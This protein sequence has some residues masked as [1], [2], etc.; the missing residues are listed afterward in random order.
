MKY[1]MRGVANDTFLVIM[2]AIV[3]LFVI[4]MESGHI[5]LAR[6]HDNTKVFENGHINVQT[7]TG[8]GQGCETTG[9][10]SPI[11]GSCTASSTDTI[12][13]G[14]PPSPCT[15]TMHPT[16]LT[17]NPITNLGRPGLFVTVTGTLTDACTG[18]V[19]G[20]ATITFTGT[21][22][23]PGLTA[24]TDAKL[25][26]RTFNTVYPRP[27]LRGTYTVQAHFAGQGIF[28]PSNSGTQTFT[29]P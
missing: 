10:T 19:V 23:P 18:S 15:P 2:A 14:T 1:N 9:G 29:V 11:S 26:Q 16:T 6:H 17:L 22:V 21:G 4:A 12:T 3:A 7:D 28:G 5:A 24:V 8:Q 13:Q 25:L 27:L 20:G